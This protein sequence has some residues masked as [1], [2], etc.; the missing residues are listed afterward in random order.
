VLTVTASISSAWLTPRRLLYLFPSFLRGDSP[1]CSFSLFSS[2][3]A[4]PTELLSEAQCGFVCQRV[5]TASFAAS[6]PNNQISFPRT[7]PSRLPPVLALFRPCRRLRARRLFTKKIYLASPDDLEE[8]INS[9]V[10]PSRLPFIFHVQSVF[11]SRVV[12]GL[13]C[14]L[15]RR[16]LSPPCNA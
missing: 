15:S 2:G 3:P 4:R 8:W 1:I 7:S 6:V 11:F 10:V 9:L 13:F 5:D 16:S 12:F 14:L